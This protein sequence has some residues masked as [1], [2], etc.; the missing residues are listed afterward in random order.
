MPC[1]P[2]PQA[3][4]SWGCERV[5]PAPLVLFPRSLLTLALKFW[6]S[7]RC[8]ESW[9]MPEEITTPATFPGAADAL[10]RPPLRHPSHPSSLPSALF[11]GFFWNSIH[12]GKQ[13][14][15]KE[16][17]QDDP[18]PA[19][20]GS[21]KKAEASF[22]CGMVKTL[23]IL[24]LASPTGHWRACSSPPAPC[25]P[26]STRQALVLYS[27]ETLELQDA[28]LV[29]QP[30]GEMPGSFSVKCPPLRVYFLKLA[31]ADLQGR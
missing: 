20:K 5:E 13:L 9:E 18:S 11:C 23:L 6:F 26:L 2:G 3:P 19:T 17:L 12:P 25:R 16:S 10:T 1:P 31:S 22:H 29:P 4:Q 28:C 8:A 24:L 30:G 27:Q 7:L 21:M 14:P 15:L